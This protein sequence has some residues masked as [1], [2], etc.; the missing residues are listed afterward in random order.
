MQLFSHRVKFDRCNHIF[1]SHLHGDHVYGLLGLLT[2]WCLK[3]RTEPLHLYSPPGLKEWVETS[4]RVC[5]VV[6]PYTL[7]FY[8]VDAASSIKVLENKDL[9]VWTIPLN[10]RS[11]LR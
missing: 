2:N 9:E 8:E 11:T 7:E 5:R 10:H 4:A 1:I 3:K 6:F